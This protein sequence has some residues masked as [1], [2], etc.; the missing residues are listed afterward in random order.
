MAWVPKD[1]GCHQRLAISTPGCDEG[2]PINKIPSNQEALALL[3]QRQG[4]NIALG[5]EVDIRHI[6]KPSVILVV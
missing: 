5:E 1:S 4:V 6:V 2:R 3:Y